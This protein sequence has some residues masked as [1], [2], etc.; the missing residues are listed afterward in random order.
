M[1]TTTPTP[2]GRWSLVKKGRIK[3]AEKKKDERARNWM[4]EVYLDSAPK[5]WKEICKEFHV[6][7]FISPYHDK[8]FSA[9]GAPKKPHY[10]LMFMFE[11]KK[12]EEQVQEMFNSFNA[13]G[14]F[15][16]NS[17]RAYARYLC[18]LDDADKAQ[19]SP[20]DVTALGGAD[21]DEVI[22]LASDTLKVLGEI[23][24]FCITNEIYSFA[25][26]S[27]YA[28]VHRRDWFRIL[29][30]KCTVYMT[31]FLKAKQWE[32][33]E[34]RYERRIDDYGNPLFAEINPDTGEVI[35]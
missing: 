18:H 29:S 14:C 32:V 6:P 27:M 35:A 24:D 31:A 15:K 3:M 19:Y 17:I 33:H 13:V 7:G 23:M 34:T 9:N 5:N 28:K 16:I 26:L 21:Y 11:G 10:H 30:T 1:G 2:C 12:S 4:C 22:G 8:D 25:E 20:E